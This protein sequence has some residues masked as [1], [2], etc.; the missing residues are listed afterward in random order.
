M[1]GDPDGPLT[2][3]IEE[4]PENCADSYKITVLSESQGQVTV[5]IVGLWGAQ[6]EAEHHNIALWQNSAP[7]PSDTPLKVL[8]VDT[9]GLPFRTVL[10]YPDLGPYDYALT[11][12]SGA[13]TSTMCALT[14]LRYAPLA[15][16]LIPDKVEL[17]I[18]AITRSALTIQYSLLSGYDPK[19]YGNWIGIWR[20]LA[21]VSQLPTPLGSAE[22]VSDA[23]MDRVSIACALE[24]G[25][26][27]TVLYLMTP[28]NPTNPA[29][30]GALYFSLPDDES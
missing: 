23:A 29:A 4:P 28:K 15:K 22:I 26:N 14:L 17:K 11:Y 20:G 13:G 24:G 27:Y 8:K 19:R 9:P 2:P 21:N 6:P 12:Q 1:T 16:A 25:Y 18:H 10:E 5:Q 3:I 30:G 7:L